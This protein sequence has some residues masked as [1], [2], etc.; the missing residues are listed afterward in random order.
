MTV[1]SGFE[2]LR[3]ERRADGVL[4]ILLDRSC[5][6]ANVFDRA[7]FDEL[8]RALD[9]VAADS[10]ARALV[11]ASAKDT[12][13][14]AGADI[15][16]ISRA[17][18]EQELSAFVERGQQVFQRVADLRI[19]TVAAIHGACLGG[20]CEL[21]LACDWRVASDSAATRIGLPEVLL[22]II[23]AWGGSTRLPRL[24]G[25]PTAL[26]MVLGGK[27]HPARR[28]RK[29][30]L[31]DDVVPRAS[32]LDAALRCVGRG[33]PKRK[34]HAL[35]NNAVAARIIAR[36]A[37]E[38][39][40]E[41]TRGHYPAVLAAVDAVTA[42]ATSSVKSSLA[43]ERR[44]VL[45]LARTESCRNLIGVFLLQERAKKLAPSEAL[46]RIADGIDELE[47][48]VGTAAVVGAGTMGAGIAHLLASRRHEVILRDV[49]DSRVRAGMQS[50]GKLVSTGVKRGA[51]DRLTAR[52][53]LDRVRPSAADV[54][55]AGVDLVIE[56][57][58]E[59]IEIKRQI[60]GRLEEL[61]RDETVLATNTSALSIDEISEDMRVPERVVGLHFFNPVHRMQLVEI[62]IGEKTSPEIGARMVRFVQAIG[63]LPVVTRNTPGFLVNRILMPYLTEAGHLFSGGSRIEEIDA[64]MLDFGMPMGPLRLIDEVGVDVA[65]HVAEFLG[66]VYRE[67]MPVPKQLGRVAEGGFLGRKSGAGFY[68]YGK[69]RKKKPEVNDAVRKLQIA[70]PLANLTREQM[71]RRMVLLMVNE[72]VR[73]LEEEVVRAPEDVDLAM[74]MGTGFA[75][76]RGGPLRYAQL[77]GLRSIVEELEAWAASGDVRFRPCGLLR[78][79]AT[80]NREF[81]QS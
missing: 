80:S 24:I 72:S 70:G 27:R 34:G 32:L 45:E 50:I 36:K 69:D 37:R 67:R 52:E 59:N 35:T 15:H 33:K 51:I 60:F 39:A 53:I 6:T 4:V 71:Q 17:E 11:F 20:G 44:L 41:K 14:V 62:V 1:K 9:E 49:D 13:F 7:T 10:S 46:P 68:V 26:D 48:A 81:F 16:E 74:V 77:T 43:D 42:G 66:S 55:L 8:S 65:G 29:I 28:A 47:P 12:I 31:V 22:G 78:E 57:A 19:V 76:F 21:A 30:G 54:P 18:T 73:C 58:I 79:M 5:S 40:L 75:P 23:P 25:L 61:S 2:R 56:A 63:K 64:A 3:L 38:K